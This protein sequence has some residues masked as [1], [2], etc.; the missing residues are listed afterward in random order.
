VAD[1]CECGY[2]PLDSVATELVSPLDQK[3]QSKQKFS[4]SLRPTGHVVL[5]ELQELST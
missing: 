2:E 5:I 1:C 4:F 3:N